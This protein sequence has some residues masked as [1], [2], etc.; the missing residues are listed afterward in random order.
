MLKTHHGIE[1][2][3][4]NA[5]V[6]ALYEQALNHVHRYEAGT[7]AKIKAMLTEQPDFLAGHLLFGT[8]LATATEARFMPKIRKIVNQV[9]QAQDKLNDRERGHLSA[10]SAFS[11][12]QWRE[13]G[14]HWGKVL[15][16]YPHDS[17]ALH[18][19]HQI[20]FITG[21]DYNLWS[22]AARVAF[23]E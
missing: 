18:A 2:S 13:A 15:T 22:R 9:A 20:D 12:G 14:F 6:V 19:A 7:G 17:L 5:N 10:L 23:V 4:S 11:Q 16:D 3:T 8:V 1:L 21:D